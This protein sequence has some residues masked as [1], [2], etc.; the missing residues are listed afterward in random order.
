MVQNLKKKIA[1]Y[2]TPP[3]TY[4]GDTTATEESTAPSGVASIGAHF[5]ETKLQFS[6]PSR[7]VDEILGAHPMYDDNFW[8]NTNPSDMSIDTTNTNEMIAGSHITE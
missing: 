2:V 7:T 1:T 5:F 4:D 8:G 6:G 3:D